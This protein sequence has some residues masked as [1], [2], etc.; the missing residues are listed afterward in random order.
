MTTISFNE[1]KEEVSSTFDEISNKDIVNFE[2]WKFQRWINDMNNGIL[3]RYWN[4][5]VQQ[6]RESR[7]SYKFPI[8]YD[9]YMRAFDAYDKYAIACK[10]KSEYWYYLV[11]TKG[12]NVKIETVRNNID[13]LLKRKDKLGIFYCDISFEHG[14]ISGREHYNM[15]LKTRGPMP[16]NRISHYEK[17]GKINYQPIKKRSDENWNNIGNY[18]NK[19]NPVE[20][21]L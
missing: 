11:W 8:P 13:K 9:T 19:E 17:S 7:V 21:L 12:P 1:L 2:E 15:R 10:N 18:C 3:N 4:N 20:Q 14:D 16:K 6:R 5:Y